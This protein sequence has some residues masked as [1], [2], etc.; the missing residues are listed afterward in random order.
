M[1][2]TLSLGRKILLVTRERELVCQVLYMCN[3]G[4]L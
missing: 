1:A 3:Y 2:K 4:G